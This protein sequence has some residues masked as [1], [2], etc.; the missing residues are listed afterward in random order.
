MEREKTLHVIPSWVVTIVMMLMCLFYLFMLFI[1]FM[2]WHID[3]PFKAEMAWEASMGSEMSFWSMIQAA[4]ISYSIIG[5]AHI[6]SVKEVWKKFMNVSLGIIHM[7]LLLLL[8]HY[9]YLN[10]YGEYISLFGPTP[11]RICGVVVIYIVFASSIVTM[12]ILIKN[13][14]VYRLDRR[15]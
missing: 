2:T 6:F 4:F 12:L 14:I 11:R 10:L 7:L 5:L 9:A 8:A 15:S 13:R 3:S 1:E